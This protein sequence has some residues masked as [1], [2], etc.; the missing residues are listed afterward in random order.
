MEISVI[1]SGS[2]GN[3][4]YIESEDASILV[5]AGISAGETE[6][7]LSCIGKDI[8]DIDAVFISHEHIDHV[9]GVERLNKKYGIQVYSNKQTFVS[10]DLNVDSP[11]YFANDA[12]FKFRDLKITPLSL[13]HDAAAACGFKIQ[14]N[15]SALGV[16]TDLGK[17]TPNIRSLPAETD[18]LVLETNHDIDM[19]INGPYPHVLK[20][21]ILS[22]KGHLS[23]V[24]AGMFVRDNASDRLKKVFLAHLSRNN[25]TQ[26]L[27]LD[28]FSK[29]VR[30]NKNIMLKP[31]L[32]TQNECTEP[33]RI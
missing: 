4:A 14:S 8:K 17:I 23:N 24:D 26:E 15:G 9:R 27:A 31:C 16:L 30:K 32:A 22:D 2:S 12:E 1:A 28:T 29:L 19:L 11:E 20:Q 25:N 18:C 10:S 13:S 6:K 3:S 33:W 5:D 7:R 21:R